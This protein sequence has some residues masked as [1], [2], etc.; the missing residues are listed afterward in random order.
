MLAFRLGTGPDSTL[1]YLEILVTSVLYICELFER[2]IRTSSK[3]KNPS[4]FF[5]IRGVHQNLEKEKNP[6]GFFDFSR[7]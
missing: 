2:F 5:D 1:C 4:G 7:L 6:S 3:E